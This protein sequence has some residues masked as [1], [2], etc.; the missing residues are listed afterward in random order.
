MELKLKAS[1]QDWSLLKEKDQEKKHQADILVNSGEEFSILHIDTAAGVDHLTDRIT[2]IVEEEEEVVVVEEEVVI[3]LGIIAGN[4]REAKAEIDIKEGDIIIDQ[5]Q[6]AQVEAGV[7]GEGCL[8][9]TS[10][11]PRDR[12][13]SRMPSSA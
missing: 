12:Q 7:E 9:Y 1:H 2:T 13:K 3:V 4:I 6:E 11:S 5:V 10:P 8:L